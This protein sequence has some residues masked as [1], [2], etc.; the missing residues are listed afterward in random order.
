MSC[1]YC[2]SRGLVE[3][4]MHLQGS[5]VTMHSCS[6]CERRWWDQEGTEV[7]LGSVLDLVS[8]R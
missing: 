1:P 2:R 3:I 4:H 6:A 7:A 8:P 5:R